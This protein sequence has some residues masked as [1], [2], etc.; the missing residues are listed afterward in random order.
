MRINEKMKII[1]DYN[2]MLIERHWEQAH[3][4]T[5]ER[6]WISGLYVASWGL[7]L[8]KKV[9]GIPCYAIY[10]IL[11]VLGI[12]ALAFCLKLNYLYEYHMLRAQAYLG[13]K[14]AK[15]ILTNFGPNKLKI[16]SISFLFCFLHWLGIFVAIHLSLSCDFF[17][18]NN[19]SELLPHYYGLLVDLF[20]LGAGMIWNKNGLS[21]EFAQINSKNNLWEKTLTI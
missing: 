6:M 5:K 20:V 18:N 12:F 14:N 21:F 15:G 17:K 2:K 1:A 10:L 3:F 7:I 9:D 4:N 13:G 19:H 11:I 16:F 8:A